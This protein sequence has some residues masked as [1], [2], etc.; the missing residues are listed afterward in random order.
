[1]KKYFS[2]E[3]LKK[4]EETIKKYGFFKAIKM[5]CTRAKKIT[6]LKMAGYDVD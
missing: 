6:Q 1:M 3:N 5:I 4:H 2:K